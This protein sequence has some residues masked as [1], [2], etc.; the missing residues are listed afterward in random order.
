MLST[1]TP[2]RLIERR[3]HSPT[4][5]VCIADSG[6]NQVTV[7]DGATNAVTAVPAGLAPGAMAANA[8]TDDPSSSRLESFHW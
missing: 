7:I 3:R 2:D 6:F 1:A 5:Q 8:Q 4:A